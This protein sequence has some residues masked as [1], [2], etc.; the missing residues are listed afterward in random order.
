M[1]KLF[2]IFLVITMIITMVHVSVSAAA[3]EEPATDAVQFSD[4]PDN[5][6]AAAL[7]NAAA[8]GLLMGS[9]GKILPDEPLTRAQMA[10][11]IVRAFG[12]TA[13]GD[14]KNYTDVNPA[15]WYADDMA[16][17]HKMGIMNGSSGK[18]YPDAYITRQ[19]VFA[20]MAR[21]FKLE[22]SE[23]INKTFIDADKLSDWARGEIYAVVNAG[24]VRGDNGMLNPQGYITRAQFAVVFDRFV[25][26]YFREAGEYT[27]VAEGNIMI[28]KPD[29]TLKDV[30]IK[31]DLIIGDGVGDGNVTLDNVAISGR[32]VVRG[33]G[34]NSI[35]ITGGSVVENIIIDR[36]ADGRI[37]VY[38]E[39]GTEVGE[40][41]ADGNDDIIIEGRIGTLTIN[42]DDV[43]VAAVNAEIGSTTVGGENFT[44]NVDENSTIGEIAVNADGAS[45][46]GTGSVAH[47]A[48]NANNIAVNTPGTSVRAAE[49]TTGVTAGARVVNPGTSVT[50]RTGVTGGT[51]TIEGPSTVSVDA[52]TIS[53]TSMTLN[54][55]G[56]TGTIIAT[57][58]P[59]NATNKTVTWVSSDTDVATVA[60]GVV[61]A[62]TAGIV[63]ITATAGG[64]T[65]AC[66]VTVESSEADFTFNAGTKTI[67]G[68]TG[69]GGVVVI[70]STINGVEVNIIG[71]GAF[72]GRTGLTSIILP[73]SLTSIG[74]Y[75]FNSCTNLTG[76]TI[77][78]S[79]T[80][81]GIFVFTGC[82]ALQSI[83]VDESNTVYSSV[84]GVLY[85]KDKTTLIT[86]PA[87]ADDYCEIPEG[88]TDIGESAF[89]GCAGLTGIEIPGSVTGIADFAFYGC[90]ALQTI[91]VDES[92]AVYSS[93]ENRVLYNK[94]K[95]ALI[96]YPAGK[97]NDSFVIP[98]S[99][100]AIGESAF[101]GCTG[102]VNVT[103]PSD[104]TSIGGYA[105]WGCSGLIS[106][107]LPDK[108]T[109]LGEGAFGDCAGLIS[110]TIGAG[111]TIGDNLLVFENNNFRDAYEAEGGGAGTYTGT[112]NGTWTKIINVTGVTLDIT[113]LT[114]SIG[115]AEGTLTA[116]VAPDDATDKSITWSSSD[117][118][119]ATVDNGTVT[120][121]AAG[122]A[123]ITVETTD[124]GKTAA[125][126]VIVESSEDDFTFN[127]ETNTITGYTGSGGVVVIPS[128]INGFE[129]KIIG[130]SAFS[131]CAGLTSIILPDSLTS[132]VYYAFG[133]CEGL[134]DIEISGS[135]TDIGD[136]VF[137]GCTA[138]KSINVD[139]SNTVYSS[140]NG[141]LYNKEKTTLITYPAGADDY[142]E[143]PEGVTDIGDSAFDGCTGL[144]SVTIPSGATGIGGYAFC[145]CIGL[146][147][148]TLPDSVT[149]IGMGAFE[150]CTGLESIK[151]SD[152]V[153]V[154]GEGAFRDCTGM[155]SITIPNGV[156]SISA[157]MFYGC[158]SL[159]SITISDNV[160][161]IETRA[162]E[163]CTELTS[164]TLPGILASINECAFLN[165]IGLTS[166]TIPNGVIDIGDSAFYGC[167]GLASITIGEDV[168]IGYY[169]LTDDD[170]FYDA[171]TAGGTGIYEKLEDGSWSKVV[172]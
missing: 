118:S 33:G 81:I 170:N 115:G 120:P 133:E 46:G 85:N 77:P 56:A 153:T 124:G 95:T 35:R 146:T 139:G 52:V 100:T 126:T 93:D 97:T 103:I 122:T 13:K 96:T 73:D 17:A 61:T 15:S 167:T 119:V 114:L 80:G 69:S 121:H 131:G 65:A 150:G 8:N 109:V 26:Q 172:E 47:V 91:D 51:T 63:S 137:Y 125:C 111:V 45:I 142:Y 132:I 24:Y 90:T 49:G 160:T 107:T 148:V 86:Y 165:C 164:V 82:T 87:G 169:L 37:R 25:V 18:L 113:A 138:L 28:N 3:K 102:L 57:V 14:I 67:T 55:G 70:P 23:T 130:D 106:I 58:S 143:I 72:S 136:R 38:A 134:T 116:T 6:S 43:T 59:V 22:P 39:D 78:G 5:W 158:N 16:K 84:N 7:K 144:T 30:K 105:F 83:N 108:V 53:P 66:T 140:V 104:V 34:A 31:G 10:A 123:T 44:L 145:G 29:V 161:V 112:M 36:G 42:A 11:V 88:V 149:D 20:I 154:I 89:D 50:V 152:K 27:T 32:V 94:D 98:D 41:I 76:I 171:Y 128:T 163:G 68:Y 48:A 62:K 64:K 12:A 168:E 60:N 117:E 127:E 1:K 155:K 2:S 79:V 74:N 135:V 129:A 54:V 156:S 101:D 40:I 4:M 162:F 71:D 110:I 159:T 99:V 141:V 147:G 92:N 9:N 19:E 166:V 157:Y 21:A 151:L 75:A